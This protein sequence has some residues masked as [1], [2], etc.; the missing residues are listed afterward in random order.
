MSALPPEADMLS[1]SINVRYVPEADMCH[2]WNCR[3][4]H[5]GGDDVNRNQPQGDGSFSGAP[6]ARLGRLGRHG[7]DGRHC[8]CIVVVATALNWGSGHLRE[9][10]FC[11][12]HQ[13]GLDLSVG[14]CLHGVFPAN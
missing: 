13:A 3:R 6:N 1:V 9:R 2:Q 10:S 11:Q 8:C 7:F 4:S 12:K 5:H 14:S